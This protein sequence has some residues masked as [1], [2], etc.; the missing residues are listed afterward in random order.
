MGPPPATPAL[1]C[2]KN[3]APGDLG[4]VVGA[5]NSALPAEG[6]LVV[7]RADAPRPFSHA[8]RPRLFARAWPRCRAATRRRL[9]SQSR[10]GSRKGPGLVRSDAATASAVDWLPPGAAGTTSARATAVETAKAP[11][12]V[13][14]HF[15]RTNMGLSFS[16][17]V[18]TRPGYERRAGRDVRGR[19]ELVIHF[20]DGSEGTVQA[21]RAAFPGEGK[22]A[23]RARRARGLRRAARRDR[24]ARCQTGC[25]AGTGRRSISHSSPLLWRA[26]R[27]GANRRRKKNGARTPRRHK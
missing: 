3:A 2:P 6:E 11:S 22:R 19:V 16:R 21:K 13:E 1:R 7:H 24:P 15:N 9:G 12:A 8:R 14:I 17:N 4:R 20:G 25:G 10:S 23:P 27:G 5:L 26:F 18:P